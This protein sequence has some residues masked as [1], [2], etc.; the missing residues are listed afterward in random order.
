MQVVVADIE[1]RS[2]LRGDH[3]GRAVADIDRREFE[4]RWLELR[5]AMIERLLAQR[6]DQSRYIGDRIG[7][8]I[9][10]GDMALNA[11]HV[12]RARLRAATSD[13]DAIAELLEIAGLAKHAVVELFAA[14]GR[15]LQQLDGTVDR[16]IFLVAGDQERDRAVT[17]LA[18]FAAMAE[19]ILK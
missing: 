2:R 4:V 7:G 10:I 14:R 11:I 1:F 19:Q 12:K 17:I 5:A 18:G 8:A 9:G 13:L 15:P 6:H 3:V 16:E